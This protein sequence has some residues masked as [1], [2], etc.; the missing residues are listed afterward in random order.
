MFQGEGVPLEKK[1]LAMERGCKTV[2]VFIPQPLAGYWEEPRFAPK[3]GEFVGEKDRPKMSYRLAGNIIAYATGFE[4]PKPR[5]E[6]QKI[7][8]PQV[9]EAKAAKRYMIELAQVRH[10]GGDW[11]PAKNAM[12]I[13]AAHVR[14]K[15]LVDVS[16]LKKEVRLINEKEV[17]A[18]KF[19]YMHGKA[20]FT[21]E[22][23]EAT[24]VRSHLAV[25]GTLFADACCGSDGFDKAFREFMQKLYPDRK[26]EPIPAEDFLYSAKLNGQ[27]IARLRCRREKADGS[28]Q[29]NYD[30]VAPMLEGIK[31]D[32]RWAIIYSR[33]DIGCA[34]EKSKSSACKGYDPESALKLASAA[35]LYSLKR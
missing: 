31:V 9:G 28:P 1:I 29:P 18:S 16:L 23:V 5:L 19:L 25:G 15:Y 21:I 30:D 13:L 33:Y 6:R 27:E 17:W 11:Q 35:L 14:E 10:D 12:R 20:A 8:D 3:V 7:I 2:V 34:L 4:P 22:E 26:L 32:G 24:N